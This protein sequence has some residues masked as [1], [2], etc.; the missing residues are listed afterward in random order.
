[1]SAKARDKALSGEWEVIGAYKF[2][3]MED[4]TMIF[5]GILCNIKDGKGKLVKALG[6]K[7]G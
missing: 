5:K 4:I 7:D 6:I 1:M 2:E 3:I